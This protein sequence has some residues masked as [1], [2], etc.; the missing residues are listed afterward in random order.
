MKVYKS[1]NVYD[2][3]LDRIRLL[4]DE[5]P[6]VMVSLSGGKDSTVI[7]EL[8]KIVARERNAL[9][10][11]VMWLDQECEF[12]ATVDYVKT[13]MYDP[14]VEPMWYQIPFKL[15]NAT[16]ATESW[17]N[18]WGEGEEWVRDKDPI[19]IKENIFGTDRFVKLMEAIVDKT[20]DHPVAVLTGVRTEESPARFMGATGDV[21]YKWI[22]WGNTI[23]KKKGVY[24]FHPIYD[25][26]YIDVWKA[27]YDHKWN[28]NRHYDE[29]FRYGTPVRKMRVSNYHH[30]TAVHSLFLLQEV[31]PQTY[32][33]ATQR[34]S[35]IDTA[36]KL[37]K[38][39]WFVYELPFMFSTW[40]EYRDYLL[41]N[42]VQDEEVKANFA[43]NFESVER[44]YSRSVSEDLWKTQI[45][46]ILC[47]DVAMT[48]LVNWETRQY[49]D[50]QLA[51][52]EAH[53]Q[54]LAE[55]FKG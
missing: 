46:S 34:I 8:T 27:I 11:K 15:L 28:Y 31:E 41:A 55:H 40:P 36:G 33:K 14:E 35:G 44:R 54:K 24:N 26:T 49:T 52:K 19:S 53:E 50:D 45:N 12:E 4:Y 21:T 38:A 30:E 1:K 32:E 10:V 18:V 16:S 39:D 42:L 7:L 9:P 43:K 2:E 23:N 37:G 6:L 3:A 25:W 51:E 20:F 48:K 13:V 22:T 29:L 17:L 5:F 47:N